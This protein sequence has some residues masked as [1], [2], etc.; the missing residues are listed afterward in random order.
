MQS[1][2]A[3]DKQRKK[4]QKEFE[5]DQRLARRVRAEQEDGGSSVTWIVIFSLLNTGFLVLA[6]FGTSWTDAQI[7]GAGVKAMQVQTSLFQLHM[8]IRCGKNPIEDKLCKVAEKMGGS[9]SLHEAQATACSI[10]N[11]ACSVM[12]R[13]Y[14][15]S[16][17]IFVTYTIAICSLL[18]GALLLNFYW[19]RSPLAKI[20]KAALASFIFAPTVAV[21]GFVVWTLIVPEMV[22]VP[23]SWSQ[24]LV[25]AL[26]PAVQGLLDFH[27]AQSFNFGWC[28]VLSVLG[29]VLMVVQLLVYAC[30]ITPHQGESAAEM[31][32]DHRKM[33]REAAA[34]GMESMGETQALL[35]HQD[36]Q[37]NFGGPPYGAQAYGP[38]M[39][40]PYPQA[41]E[42]Y[43]QAGGPYP[44]AGGPYPQMGTPGPS[45]PYMDPT[46]M[47]GQMYNPGM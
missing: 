8:E 29:H 35:G 45:G 12:D 46:G 32:E 39:G 43:P 3:T 44:Q 17:L 6:M 16:F 23:R 20:R 1:Y 28:W 2:P 40:G 14:W 7:L 41:G 10:S 13:I 47:P 15:C 30:W 33:Q 9:H 11:L 21:T 19:F 27:S 24:A 22:E 26:G 31:Q 34:I 25:G 5:R 36:Q 4:Q 18:M 42:P 38:E 37:Q